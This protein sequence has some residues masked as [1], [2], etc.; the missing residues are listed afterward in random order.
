MGLALLVATRYFDRDP[1]RH[2]PPIPDSVVSAADGT[3]LAV[4]CL[5]FGDLSHEPG[6]VDLG[7]GVVRSCWSVDSKAWMVSVFMSILDVHVNRAP[8]NGR[9]IF[10]T[11]RPG[12]FFPLGGQTWQNAEE[13]ER[14]TILMRS[15]AG[16]VGVIQVAGHLA[17][18]IECWVSP[19][20]FVRQGDRIGKIKLGSGVIVVFPARE[21][22]RILV[23]EGDVV[24]AGSTLLAISSSLP[25]PTSGSSPKPELEQ[26]KH[27]IADRILT[28]YL[29]VVLHGY[30]YTRLWLSALGQRVFGSSKA[31]RS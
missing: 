14:N 5:A 6:I 31:G 30:L 7:E 26:A 8:V 25:A 21:N 12:S 3:V 9:I 23:R 16:T 29:S 13:N 4:K 15:E 1:E 11:L 28:K 2:V 24:R 17:R 20:D 22:Q 10:T 18:R 19:G 27:R